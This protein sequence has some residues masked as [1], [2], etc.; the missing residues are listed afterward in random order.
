MSGKWQS[1]PPTPKPVIKDGMVAPIRG[2]RLWYADSKGEGEPIVLLHG[3]LANSDCWGHQVSALIEHKFR[4]IL[5]DS[6][7]HGRSSLDPKVPLGYSV[8][9]D[10]VIALLDYLNLDQVNV[11]GWSDGGIIGINLAMRYPQR[12]LRVVAFGANTNTSGLKSDFTSNPTCE[13][14]EKRSKREYEEMSP[15]P[16]EFHQLVEAVMHMWSS[17]PNY[18]DD[19]LA[20]ITRTPVLI[21]DGEHDEGISLEHNHYMTRA[22]PTASEVILP[23]T[24]HFAFL[25]DPLAFNEVMFKYLNINIQ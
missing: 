21:F 1:V 4:V 13:E 14:Y 15:T 20:G 16:A 12:L 25:Q 22:I 11:L 23:D 5:V 2:I 3:G 8:M 7:G 17:E 24:S 10:D 18:S 19:E 9:A 6:R